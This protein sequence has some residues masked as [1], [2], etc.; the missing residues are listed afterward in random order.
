MNNVDKSNI[1]RQYSI[2]VPTHLKPSSSLVLVFH[3]LRLEESL[4][5]EE[6]GGRRTVLVT[7][8][9]LRGGQSVEKVSR[10]VVIGD[11]QE[12]RVQ[13]PKH[14]GSEVLL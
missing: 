10:D 3:M 5:N 11:S 7:V 12:I 8:Q 14:L 6:V 9:L 4:Q 2:L 1:F 13:T